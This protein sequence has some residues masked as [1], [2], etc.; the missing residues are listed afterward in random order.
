MEYGLFHSTLLLRHFYRVLKITLEARKA[1]AW[2]NRT[3]RVM[4]R[5]GLDL[6]AHPAAVD[7]RSPHQGLALWRQL[8]MDEGEWGGLG[9]IQAHHIYCALY[10]YYC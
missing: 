2:S 6:R 3:D 1:W 5:A 8:S 4:R 9:R 10:V 7:Q